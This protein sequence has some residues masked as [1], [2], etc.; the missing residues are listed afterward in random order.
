MSVVRSRLAPSA[1]AVTCRTARSSS[2]S[3][4]TTTA[5]KRGCSRRQS[6]PSYNQEPLGV[7]RKREGF[8]AIGRLLLPERQR[9]SMG[10]HVHGVRIG[11]DDPVRRDDGAAGQQ[12]RYCSDVVPFSVTAPTMAIWTAAGITRSRTSGDPPAVAGVQVPVPPHVRSQSVRTAP[13]RWPGDARARYAVGA[14]G[15]GAVCASSHALLRVTTCGHGSEA[16]SLVGALIGV[17]RR[18]RPS[19]AHASE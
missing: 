4:A 7:E 15:G 9:G 16:V 19:S 1:S 14:G 2:G 11:E 5:R 17:P 8:S 18:A 12:V 3:C 10:G 13:G 6:V